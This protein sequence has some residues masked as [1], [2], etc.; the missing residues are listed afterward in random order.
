MDRCYKMTDE[1]RALK[2][3]SV[4]LYEDQIEPLTILCKLKLFDSKNDYF[5]QTVDE[6]IKENKELL[7]RLKII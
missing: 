5:R 2:Q 6:F 7:D 4:L 3:V 1:K